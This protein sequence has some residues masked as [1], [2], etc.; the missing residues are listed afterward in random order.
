VH[1]N[2]T[3]FKTKEKLAEAVLD[4]AWGGTFWVFGGLGSFAH[5]L[6]G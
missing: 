2:V 4:G 3:T 6:S 5:A 1:V